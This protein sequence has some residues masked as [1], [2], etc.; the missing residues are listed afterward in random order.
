MILCSSMIQ[1]SKARINRFRRKSRCSLWQFS[2]HSSLIIPKLL[3]LVII[4]KSKVLSNRLITLKPSNPHRRSIPSISSEAYIE[5]W[6]VA[7]V[8]HYANHLKMIFDILFS[9]FLHRQFFVRSFQYI[10]NANLH[11]NN[12]RR[13]FDSRIIIHKTFGDKIN[14]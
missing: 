10:T 6:D 12:C 1:L 7:I 8:L 14:L 2:T 13:S 9:A 3:I 4:W 11:S 5:I